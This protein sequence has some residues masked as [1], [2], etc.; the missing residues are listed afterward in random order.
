MVRKMS[1]CT[2]V[3]IAVTLLWSLGDVAL[4][5]TGEQEI[6]RLASWRNGKKGLLLR[7]SAQAMERTASWL[8]K[9]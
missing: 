7:I 4:G 8:P 1:R 2:I 3:A 9:K 5:I 6:T